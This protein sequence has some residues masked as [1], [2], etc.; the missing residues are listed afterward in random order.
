MNRKIMPCPTVPEN[1]NVVANNKSELSCQIKLLTPLFGGGTIAQ[2]VDSDFPIRPTTIRGHLRFWWRATKG[3]GYSD[4]NEL[5]KAESAIWGS[6]DNPSQIVIKV[7][8]DKKEQVTSFELLNQ[9]LIG[10]YVLFPFKIKNNDQVATKLDNATFT[11]NIEYPTNLKT[12]LETALKAW[13]NFGGLGTRTRRGCGALCCENY[14]F[15]TTQDIAAFVGNTSESRFP[16][17]GKVFCGQQQDNSI[18]AWCL[19][20]SPL[21]EFRQGPDIGRNIGQQQNRPGRSR[22][23]EPD[24][25]RRLFGTIDN[26]SPIENENKMPDAFPRAEFG[27]P[28]I[29]KFVGNREN[30]SIEPIVTAQDGDKVKE[31][32]ASPLILRPIKLQDGTIRPMAL[33]LNGPRPKK[34]RI[35]TSHS[36]AN[37]IV[38]TQDGYPNNSPMHGESSALA[39]FLKHISKKGFSEVKQ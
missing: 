6:T 32:F 26:H 30:I 10:Q 1:G 39:A 35:T 15:K 36:S 8:V 7:K 20:I 16:T 19:S 28:I 29:T 23:P 4:G 12:D 9:K 2:Y 25:I 17:I 33:L 18:N 22:W 14:A 27:L 13:V 21:Q 34:V 38:N 3:A 5:R 31:R 37:G 24:T 11:L